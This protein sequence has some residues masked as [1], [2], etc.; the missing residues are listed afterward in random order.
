MIDAVFDRIQFLKEIEFPDSL[1]C[2]IKEYFD[3]MMC[4][5]NIVRYL[6]LSNIIMES[7][8]SVVKFSL[9]YID[10]SDADIIEERL[11]NTETLKIYKSVFSVSIDRNENTLNITLTKN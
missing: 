8:D 3:H 4:M 6:P 11:K 2:C 7:N 1:E 10:S 9:V 5:Y